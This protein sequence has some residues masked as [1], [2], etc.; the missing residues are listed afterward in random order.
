[1]SVKDGSNSSNKVGA[2]RPVSESG[3]AKVATYLSILF[4]GEPLMEDAA[5]SGEQSSP[6]VNS[7]RKCPSR[8]R[9]LSQSQIQSSWKPRLRIIG[10]KELSWLLCERTQFIMAGS[11]GRD[12]R[13]TACLLGRRERGCPASLLLFVLIPSG[14]S[15]HGVG[16]P[17]LLPILSSPSQTLSK[18]YLNLLSDSRSSQVGNED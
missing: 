17:T 1:M 16:V 15:A 7:P 14:L 11:H 10:R 3:Q 12:T 5:R 8:H 6:L 18:V 13:F 9:S 2:H 4:T